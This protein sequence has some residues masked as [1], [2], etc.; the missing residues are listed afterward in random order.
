MYSWK[1]VKTERLKNKLGAGWVYLAQD[2]VGIF[3][4]NIEPA[5]CIKGG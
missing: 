3:E 2:K 4:D 5:G 1:G